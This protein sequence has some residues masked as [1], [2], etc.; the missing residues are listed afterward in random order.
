M[1]VLS[2]GE[3]IDDPICELMKSILDGHILLSRGLAEQGHFPAIDIPRSISRQADF[4]AD[5]VLRKK[6]R[7]VQ[8]WLSQHEASRTLIDAGLYTKGGNL[9]LD[10]AIEKRPAIAAFLQQDRLQRTAFARTA[11]MLTELVEA[12]N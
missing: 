3:E 2:E 10:Q 12:R 8:A 6:A 1:T 9:E 4:L 7:K 5:E 11:D